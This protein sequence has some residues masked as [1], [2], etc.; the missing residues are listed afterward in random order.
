[1]RE[2]KGIIASVISNYLF[3]LI[4]ILH[5]RGAWLGLIWE[6]IEHQA[7]REKFSICQPGTAGISMIKFP[8][9]LEKVIFK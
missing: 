6:E 5:C 9:P 1:M 7:R 8:D 2:I 3:L 4:V